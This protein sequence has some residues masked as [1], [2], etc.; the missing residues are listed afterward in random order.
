MPRKKPRSSPSTDEE[1]RAAV[2][3]LIPK[4]E[5]ESETEEAE[6]DAPARRKSAKRVVNNIS[7]YAE[8]AEEDTPARRKLAPRMV[9]NF[10]EDEKEIIIDF[11]Q[12]NPTLYS[13]R[14]YGYKDVAA[15]DR[16][17]AEQARKMD[18]SPNELKTW[19]DSMRTKLGKLKKAVT[20]SGKAAA[21]FTATEWWLWQR[22]QFLLEHINQMPRRTAASSTHPLQ[23]QP[24]VAAGAHPAAPAWDAPEHASPAP[25]AG[26]PASTHTSS[27]AGANPDIVMGLLETFLT[28][29]QNQAHPATAFGSYVDGSLRSLPPAIRRTA[30]SRIMEVLHQCQD[31]AD[32]R[33]L[34]ASPDSL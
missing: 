21:L 29:R 3:D 12:Q 7:D 25:P 16:L 26:T 5:P 30:E 23:V 32:R 28:E 18:C 20:T 9:T 14:L 13:K 34:E 8:E 4:F 2:A 15:K 27:T 31:E 1:E 17:W 33:A 11:L 24:A 22:F 19:Y 6:E 10:S